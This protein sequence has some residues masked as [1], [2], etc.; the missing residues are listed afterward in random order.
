MPNKRFIASLRLF[1]WNNW[2]V[3]Y[4]GAI[5]RVIIKLVSCNYTY[6]RELE[7]FN[8]VRCLITSAVY[9]RKRECSYN[10]FCK[11]NS[12]VAVG[13][14][15]RLFNLKQLIGWLLSC[16][17]ASHNKADSMV[18]SLLTRIRMKL[19]NFK[20][21]N[22]AGVSNVRAL[23]KKLSMINFSIYSIFS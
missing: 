19:L 3:D 22:A 16:H 10:I 7:A 15:F 9:L 2:S 13:C 5:W 23:V 8:A 14:G 11:I 21:S 17:L 1:T 18:Y 20:A 12:C 4:W 6:K